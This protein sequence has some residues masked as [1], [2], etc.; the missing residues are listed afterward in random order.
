MERAD[1]TYNQQEE[2]AHLQNSV[3]RMRQD[4]FDF[5]VH[6]GVEN[7]EPD[8]RVQSTLIYCQPNAFAKDAYSPDLIQQYLGY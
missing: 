3:Q 6:P 7:P 4:F 8:R 2:K 5:H 1:R